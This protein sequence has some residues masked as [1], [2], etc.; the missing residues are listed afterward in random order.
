M[1]AVWLMLGSFLGYVVAYNTVGRFLPRRVRDI[2]FFVIF[3]ELLIVTL[4]AVSLNEVVFLAEKKYSLAAISGAVLALSVWMTVEGGV[5]L[6]RPPESEK[7]S[8]EPQ[9]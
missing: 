2:F 9:P 4:W 8:A 7:A 1:G 3:L 6:F 5:T